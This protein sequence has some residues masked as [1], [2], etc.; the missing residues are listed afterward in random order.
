MNIDEDRILNEVRLVY[1]ELTHY[2]E[3]AQSE[4]FLRCYAETPDFLAVS[5]DGIIRN[6]P[7]F[8]KVC[9]EYYDSLKVQKIFTS[10]EVYRVLDDNTVSLCWSGNIEAFFKNGDIMK[11]PH[12]TVTFLFSKLSGEWK[13]VQSHESSLPPQIIK[14]K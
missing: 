14:S 4:L 12:Y 3:T 7:E 9:K 6:F 8:K 10:D 5:A 11:M 1:E 13:I 2:S